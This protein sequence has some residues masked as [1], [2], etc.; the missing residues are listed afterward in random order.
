MNNNVVFIS[1]DRERELRFGHKALK[2][3]V[4]LTGKELVDIEQSF[5]DFEIVEKVVYCGLLR[6][7]TQRGEN[8]KLEDMADILDQAPT[9]A[10]I[11]EKMTLAFNAA[12]GVYP[13]QDQVGN[14][15]APGEVPAEK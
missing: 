4:A 15:Q 8:L 12:W 6:D 10:H 5:T 2:Q 13:D 14:Q 1:L 11:L 9:Y 3:L 7:A